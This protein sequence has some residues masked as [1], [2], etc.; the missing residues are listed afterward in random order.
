M[1]A[2][3]LAQQPGVLPAA[4]VVPVALALM[5]V[6]GMYQRA[7]HRSDAAESRRR[8]RLANGWVMLVNLPILAVGFAFVSSA[9]SPRLFLLVWILAMGLLA[10]SVLLAMLDVVNT[11]RM[12]QAARRRLRVLLAARLAAER[13]AQHTTRIAPHEQETGRAG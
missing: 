6:V 12:A 13:A 4:L 11:W 5:A 8:I 10:V 9:G 7:M 2:S 3:G 1:I